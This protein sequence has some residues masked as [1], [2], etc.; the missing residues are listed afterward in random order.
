MFFL[1]LSILLSLLVPYYTCP[2]ID[3]RADHLS[4][5]S[6]VTV[7][8]VDFGVELSSRD[9]GSGK[10][11]PDLEERQQFG[12]APAWNP[13]RTRTSAASCYPICSGSLHGCTHCRQVQHRRRT[14][15]RNPVPTQR[16]LVRIRLRVSPSRPA[17]SPS[18][19]ES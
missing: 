9:E 5:V 13:P 1:I 7:G 3:S 4:C 10:W 6:A 14:H 8:S 2:V 12:R 16:V 17:F 15:S 11:R 19:V 18:K